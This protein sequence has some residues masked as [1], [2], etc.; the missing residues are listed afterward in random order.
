MNYINK[1]TQEVTHPNAI[2]LFRLVIYG[3]VILNT[4]FLLPAGNHF[5]SF[6]ALIPVQDFELMSVIKKAFYLL[7]NEGLSSYWPILVGIQLIAAVLA[8]FNKWPVI[9]SI[10]VY[11]CTINLDNRANVILDGGNNLMHIILVFLIFMKPNSGSLLSN[12]ITN[13]SFLMA[14]IQVVFVYLCAGLGKVTGTLWPQGVALYYTMNVDEYGHPLM[15]ELMTDYSLLMVGGAYATLLFQ[16]SFPWLVW[17]R[18]TRP[19]LL[20]MGTFFHLGIVF[21]MGLVSFGFAMCASYFVFYDDKRAEK[22]MSLFRIKG[23]L[24]VGFDENCRVCQKFANVTAYL[25]PSIIK[26][27]AW[28][29]EAS[30]LKVVPIEERVKELI[31]INDKGLTFRGVDALAEVVYRLPVGKV[32]KPA[33]VLMNKMGIGDMLYLKL[34]NSKWRSNCEKGL[35]ELKVAKNQKVVL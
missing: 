24:T 5:W 20:A 28:Q 8:M 25:S 3:W 13:A 23:A 33:F 10:V 30:A 21:G 1:I 35:C 16:L 15:A 34:A 11:F 18:K 7:H 26:D 27:N 32:F 31:A 9:S 12:G 17:F 6:N 4:L 22:F 29:P 19:F 14:R 2:K